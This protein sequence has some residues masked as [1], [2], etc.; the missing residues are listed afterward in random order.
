M[1]PFGDCPGL[2]LV[3]AKI[4]NVNG[5]VAIEFCAFRMHRFFNPT[6]IS[7]STNLKAK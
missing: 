6:R 2:A 3:T 1:I 4:G 7:T 5:A